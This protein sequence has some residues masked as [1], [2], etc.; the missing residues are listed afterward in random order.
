MTSTV[1]LK[2]EDDT[3]TPPEGCARPLT[4]GGSSPLDIDPAE[5]WA[6][7][8]DLDRPSVRPPALGRS[9]VLWFVL[10][11]VLYFAGIWIIYTTM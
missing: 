4:A 3:E 11:G 7:K 9:V 8:D 5:P 6:E 1:D 2:P 10:L